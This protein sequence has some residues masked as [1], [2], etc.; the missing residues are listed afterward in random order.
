MTSD[1]LGRGRLDQPVTLKTLLVALAASV[2]LAAA[3]GAAVS[4]LVIR[5]GDQGPP[6]PPG[7]QGEQGLTG[8]PGPEGPG[9]PRG[10]RGPEGQPGPAGEVDEESVFTAIENDPSRVADTVNDGGPTTAELCDAFNLY[11]GD[12]LADVYLLGC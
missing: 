5:E 10:A 7:P 9:G 4:A 3:G 8:D 11:G 6:G 2:V 1:T 12:V